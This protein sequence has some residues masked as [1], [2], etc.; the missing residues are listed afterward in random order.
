MGGCWR[1]GMPAH[2][3]TQI[4]LFTLNHAT[5]VSDCNCVANSHQGVVCHYGLAPYRSGAGTLERQ[6]LHSLIEYPLLHFDSTI[7]QYPLPADRLL[8]VRGWTD[9]GIAPHPAL[10]PPYRRVH[11]VSV[12]ASVKRHAESSL[13]LD[14]SQRMGRGTEGSG[15]PLT[16]PYQLHN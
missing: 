13:S 7:F 6:H 3:R 4:P 11:A 8:L 15:R 9:Q 12:R 10:A 5:V 16:I 14:S 2:G 1:A